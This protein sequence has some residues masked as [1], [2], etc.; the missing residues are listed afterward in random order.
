MFS[1]ILLSRK[2]ARILFKELHI[3]GDNLRDA[4]KEAISTVS[5]LVCVLFRGNELAIIRKLLNE[6]EFNVESL[7]I[8]NELLAKLL[9]GFQLKDLQDFA[10]QQFNSWQSTLPSWLQW[11][12]NPYS[13]SLIRN[14]PSFFDN[15]VRNTLRP[16]LFLCPHA[17]D[18]YRVDCSTA[19][20]Y[21]KTLNDIL[22]AKK[23]TS[24]FARTSP[25][26]ELT[27]FYYQLS[28]IAKLHS[29]EQTYVSVEALLD[30]KI[31]YLAHRASI[32]LQE[33]SRTY[34]PET[35]FSTTPALVFA[36]LRISRAAN[37][38]D[39]IHS[40]LTPAKVNFFSSDWDIT[41][42][43]ARTQALVA[44]LKEVL[45]NASR[46]TSTSVLTCAPKS[47]ITSSVEN[48]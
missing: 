5:L 37:E 3:P 45:N 8:S 27:Q 17:H 25:N 19:N 28:L 48:A 23:A 36:L 4:T 29:R 22:E 10:Y 13:V 18:S 2:L 31:W 30:S 15:K 46:Q 35:L 38:L 1:R 9:A 12:M 14:R 47:T 20:H 6:E 7:E 26:K 40:A 32:E 11:T 34:R 39:L 21:N 24:L 44:A 41:Q 16:N 43:P 33:W 42:T